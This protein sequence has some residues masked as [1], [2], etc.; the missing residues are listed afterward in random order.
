[1]MTLV[2][3]VDFSPQILAGTVF[4]WRDDH[5]QAL[6]AAGVAKAADPAPVQKRTYRRR[7]LQAEA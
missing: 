4:D 7:D 6:I 3:L 1:M 5:A 2:A